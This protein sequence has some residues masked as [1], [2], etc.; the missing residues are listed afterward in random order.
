MFVF[1]SMFC[2]EIWEMQKT[3]QYVLSLKLFL[4]NVM[5]PKAVT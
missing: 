3:T 2:K 4:A 1:N 5:V